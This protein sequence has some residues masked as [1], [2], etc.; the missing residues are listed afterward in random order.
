MSDALIRID[1]GQRTGC[2]ENGRWRKDQQE[3]GPASSLMVKRTGA[4]RTGDA[5]LPVAHCRLA[6]R[7]VKVSAR[8]L[9]GWGALGEAVVSPIFMEVRDVVTE[10]AS[11]VLFVQRNDVVQDLSPAAADP[12][13]A[14]PFCQG[15]WM[16]VCRGCRPVAF[17]KAATSPSNFESRSKMT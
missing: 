8:R 13:S 16:L 11:G 12:S 7:L 6:L 10:K 2:R 3:A 4:R 1:V 17:K 5:Y 9:A 14:M 15:D